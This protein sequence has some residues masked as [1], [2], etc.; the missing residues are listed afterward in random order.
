MSK[1]FGESLLAQTNAERSPKQISKWEYIV[2]YD[3]SANVCEMA[4]KMNEY[5]ANGWELITVIDSED[6][7]P[8]LVYKRPRQ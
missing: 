2:I 4:E 8:K 5:G 3:G 7:A 6:E 1:E